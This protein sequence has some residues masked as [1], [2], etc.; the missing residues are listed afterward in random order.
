[1]F[2]IFMASHLEQSRLLFV[3][4]C[5]Q[6]IYDSKQD[7]LLCVSVSAAEDVPMPE[8]MRM[9]VS[10]AQIV[11]ISP[12]RK[13]QFRHYEALVIALTQTGVDK[14]SLQNNMTSVFAML[15]FIRSSAELM[16]VDG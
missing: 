13:S 14:A 12:S 10:K 6:S 3:R 4:Q 9:I 2:S 11:N 7:S 8:A 15:I 5:V 16:G 1:M